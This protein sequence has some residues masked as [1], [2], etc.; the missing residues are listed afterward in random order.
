MRH[1]RGVP[2]ADDLRAAVRGE[3]SPEVMSFWQSDK[4]EIDFV[5]EPQSF[6]EVKRGKATPMDFEW[7]PHVFPEG[8]LTVIGESRFET[9]QIRGI[10]L[11]DFLE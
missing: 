4:H 2:L 11:T 7:F 10:T 9:D 1:D 8:R 6:I 3:E 5:V